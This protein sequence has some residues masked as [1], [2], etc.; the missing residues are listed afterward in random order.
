ERAAVRGPDGR[1]RV[2]AARRVLVADHAAADLE[3]PTGG[4]R[5]GL[6]LLVHEEIGARVRLDL[7]R[8]EKADEGNAGAVRRQ[9]CRVDRSGEVHDRLDG[10]APGGNRVEVGIGRL[11]VRLVDGVGSE[12][13]LRAVRAP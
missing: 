12:I 2:A 1:A 9:G 4:Q 7:A 13:D 11:V 10:S 8:I 6:P 5:D 3:I